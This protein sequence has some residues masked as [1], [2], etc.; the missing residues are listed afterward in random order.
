MSQSVACGLEALHRD[1][2]QETRIFIRMIDKFFDCLNVRSYL[3]GT[4][5]R[6]DNILPYKSSSDERFEVLNAS[7]FYTH[8]A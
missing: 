2:T 4:L 8:N 6:N 3:S 7:D 5:K 1:G